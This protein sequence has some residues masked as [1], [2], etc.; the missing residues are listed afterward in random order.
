MQKGVE[1][2]CL[3]VLE[4]KGVR[5]HV[6]QE[7]LATKCYFKNLSTVLGGKAE[8]VGTD[9]DRWGGVGVKTCGLSFLINSIFLTRSNTFPCPES[10]DKGQIAGLRGTACHRAEYGS[11]TRPGEGVRW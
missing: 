4:Q 11:V 3:C 10:E 1:N 6:G 9:A 5:P 2:H 8:G 7:G